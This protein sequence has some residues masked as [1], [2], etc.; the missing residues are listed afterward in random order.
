[1]GAKT[2]MQKPM[3]RSTVILDWKVFAIRWTDTLV[4]LFTG[5]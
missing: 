4:F 2:R 5:E 1:V 3:A